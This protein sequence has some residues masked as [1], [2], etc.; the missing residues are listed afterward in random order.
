MWT[1]DESY[2]AQM[3]TYTEELTLERAARRAN[4][5]YSSSVSQVRHGLGH[6]TRCRAP[7]GWWSSC[8]HTAIV[9]VKAA[10]T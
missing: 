8:E 3:I 2:E 10:R 5:L 1:Q 4:K 7:R 6:N 9:T